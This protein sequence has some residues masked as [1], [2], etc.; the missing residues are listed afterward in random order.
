MPLESTSAM[1]TVPV[2][3]NAVPLVTLAVP[4]KVVGGGTDVPRLDTALR[5]EVSC[6]ASSS[7]WD[8]A[9]GRVS[10]R[11]VTSAAILPEVIC[12]V[13]STPFTVMPEKP[14]DA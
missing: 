10:S 12:E 2:P 4:V 13:M 3:E 1:R 7:S 8:C 5:L 6:W 9:A 14:P 11:S